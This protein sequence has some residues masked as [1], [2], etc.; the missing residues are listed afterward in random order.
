MQVKSKDGKR[1]VKLERG[2]HTLLCKA[3]DICRELASQV[4]DKPADLAAGA[5]L[6]VI[7]SYQPPAP[8]KR[9][10]AAT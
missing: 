3:R 5:L 7:E 2:E 10:E 8:K 1:T 9:Q 4:D 6:K